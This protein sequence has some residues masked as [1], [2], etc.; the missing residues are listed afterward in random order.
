[1]SD[2][3]LICKRSEGGAETGEVE[4]AGLSAESA[5]WRQVKVGVRYGEGTEGSTEGGTEGGTSG[6]G[7]S[8][9]DRVINKNA[10]IQRTRTMKAVAAARGFSTDTSLEDDTG[11]TRLS[12][13]TMAR[14][15]PA[16]PRP[17]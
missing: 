5:V 7:G 2:A 10:R 1:M 12:R 3:A 13:P 9:I 15:R 8:E 16:M 4:T 17:I 11:A 14:A 6:G